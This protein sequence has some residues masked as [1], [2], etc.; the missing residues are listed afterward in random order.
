MKHILFITIACAAAMCACG[1]KNEIRVS[2]KILFV[3]SELRE[4]IRIVRHVS[5]RIQGNLLRVRT[6]FRNREDENIWIDIQVSWR[7]SEGFEL[8][9]TNWAA[10]QVPVGV[11]VDHDISSMR[12]DVADYEFRI[13]SRERDD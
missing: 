5:D 13:R 11:L 7:D 6:Q 1:E 10:F 2:D 12:A 4:D 3:D 9:K 8:Y